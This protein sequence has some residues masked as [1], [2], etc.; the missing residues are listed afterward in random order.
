MPCTSGQTE[1]GGEAG[2]QPALG[3]LLARDEYVRGRLKPRWRD[4]DYLVLADLR[5]L[6]VRLAPKAQGRLFD[7]GCGAAPYRFFFSHCSNYVGAD[8]TPGPSVDRLL[9]PDGLTTELPASYDVVLST[10]VLEHVKDPAAY[11]QECFRILRPGGRLILSTHGMAEE[12]G[13]PFD[14]HRWTSRGLENLAVEHGFVIRES[15]KFTTELRG[16]VQLLHQ[17]VLHLRCPH[18]PLVRYAL[19]A[20]RRAYGWICLPLL[21]WGA[22][23]LPHQAIVPGSDPASLY[24]GICIVAEKPGG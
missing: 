7:Y 11:L 9:E 17:F 20:V 5:A 1:L 14:F 2:A 21:N 6:I 10:Q 18:R 23:Q 13:C 15:M 12:H 22:D 19:A 24:V 8:V 16:A 3:E 4:L